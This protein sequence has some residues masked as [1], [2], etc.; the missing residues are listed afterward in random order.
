MCCCHQLEYLHL[1]EY[2][3][4]LEAHKD[5]LVNVKAD[6]GQSVSTRYDRHEEVIDGADQKLYVQQERF[7]LG[8]QEM[9]TELSLLQQHKTMLQEQLQILE[10]SKPSLRSVWRRYINYIQV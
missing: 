1:T 10:E 7:K 4:F 6:M 8:T 2:D 3:N 5:E 9:E